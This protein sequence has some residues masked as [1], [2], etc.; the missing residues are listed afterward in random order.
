VVC[1]EGLEETAHGEVE[2]VKAPDVRLR[3]EVLAVSSCPSSHSQA[4]RS[5]VSCPLRSRMWQS[6]EKGAGSELGEEALD[7]LNAM[8]RTYVWTP[9]TAWQ[10]A[11]PC[12]ALL[13]P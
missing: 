6:L 10:W 2:G 1:R 8:V 3:P 12:L 5:L 13:R 7:A 9:C 11:W 4:V